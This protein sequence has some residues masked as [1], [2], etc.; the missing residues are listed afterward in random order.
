MI[1]AHV[2]VDWEYTRSSTDLSLL[3]GDPH[4]L[5]VSE[6]TFCVQLNTFGP[7]G[8]WLGSA[9]A[10]DGPVVFSDSRIANT[11]VYVSTIVQGQL[12]VLHVEV[13]ANG[14]IP[15]PTP[16]ASPTSTPTPTFVI[17]TPDQQGCYSASATVNDPFSGQGLDVPAGY[18]QATL[19]WSSS[20]IHNSGVDP[21]ITAVVD[22]LY[23]T[24]PGDAAFDSTESWT[25]TT[26]SRAGRL[27][28]ESS[29]VSGSASLTLCPVA[30]PTP[31]DTPTPTNTRTPGPTNTPTDTPTPSNTPT[32]T[33]TAS[34]T[35]TATATATAPTGQP[36]I[37]IE[38][39]LT[40]VCLPTSTPDALDQT[41]PA[42]AL[43]GLPTWAP[44][45]T[46]TAT[47]A[48]SSSG[49][50]SISYQIST[51]LAGPISHTLA[52]SNERFGPDGWARGA[53]DA[54]PIAASFAGLFGFLSFFTLFGQLNWFL[55]PMLISL[56]VRVTRALLS[57]TKYIKQIL[58]F[59]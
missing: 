14:G 4:P 26:V 34:A 55:P 32:A 30:P 12:V 42:P 17:P 45:A 47:I 54:S 27:Q 10:G 3:Q 53:T 48:I 11:P 38:T 35:A 46:L 18:Y 2:T 59:Q 52:L 40:A 49:L 58:P 56:L 57:V 6:N 9:C 39:G 21:Y 8:N 50:I 25:V 24:V 37:T 43:A 19:S 16:T 33:A 7:L 31:T 1:T 44:L 51:A 22:G 5:Q 15:T 23:F 28:I 29:F 20:P 41:G 36:T 13:Y